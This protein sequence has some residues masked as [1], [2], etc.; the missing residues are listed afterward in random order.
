[1]PITESAGMSLCD[2]LEPSDHCFLASYRRIPYSVI[3]SFSHGKY[4]CLDGGAFAPVTSY[5]V[6]SNSADGV[7]ATIR[8][9]RRGI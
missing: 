9:S 6:R 5:F 8:A 4:V 2:R 3:V 7:G 1:M